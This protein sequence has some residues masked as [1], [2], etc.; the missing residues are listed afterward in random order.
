MRTSIHTPRFFALRSGLLAVATTLALAGCGAMGGPNE[1]SGTIIGGVLGGAVGSQVGGGSGRTV[2]TVIG[3]MIGASIGANVGRSMDGN[4]RART[5]QV[6][7]T[8]PT[9]QPSGWVN[10]DTRNQYTVTPTRTY[11]NGNTPC[12]DY[13]MRAVVNGQPDN[14]HGTACRQPDGSWRVAN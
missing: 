9:G 2:A 3:T 7:E 8:A 1:A 10:P 13:T 12:R 4:D 6:F 14:V 11:Q 5:A